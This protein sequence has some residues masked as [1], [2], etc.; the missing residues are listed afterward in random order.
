[1]TVPPTFIRCDPMTTPGPDERLSAYFDGELSA[2]ERA[3]VERLLTERSDLQNELNGLAD[4]SLRLNDLA[5]ELPD[6]D[7]RSRVMAQIDRTRRSTPPMPVRTSPPTRQSWMP[8]FLSVC[9]LALLAAVIWPLL[10]TSGNMPQLA[11]H[12]AAGYKLSQA[13]HSAVNAPISSQGSQLAPNEL[14]IVMTTD[15]SLDEASL[16]PEAVNSTAALSVS[17]DGKGPSVI[18]AQIERSRGLKAGEIVS[19]MIQSGD[20]P[21]LAEYTVVDVRRSAQDVEVL[22][23]EHGIQPL[24]TLA[25]DSRNA[26]Q[27]ATVT[28]DTESPLRVYLLD[29]ETVS[30]NTAITE[31]KGLQEV[32]ATKVESYN[33]SPQVESIF[34]GERA[35]GAPSFFAQDSIAPTAPTGRF[36]E[37]LDG[38]QPAFPAK[39]TG[40]AAR[41]SPVRGKMDA[42]SVT[43][44][45]ESPPADAKAPAVTV[46]QSRWPLSTSSVNS[47]PANIAGNSLVVE[48]GVEV[49]A[50]LQNAMNQT[51]LALQANQRPQVFPADVNQNSIVESRVKDDINSVTRPESQRMSM[52]WR[53][54]SMP[55]QQKQINLSRQR[56]FLVLRP[57]VPPASPSQPPMSSPQS[58]ASAQ[59]PEP[60]QPV[61]VQAPD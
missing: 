34:T 27:P 1:M 60:P 57:Q 28:A 45:S 36:H 54:Q 18:L 19:R 2:A 12:D 51:K 6:F 55:K 42:Y 44:P 43:E 21:M 5:E 25:S 59:P 10:L 31:C 58:A 35:P 38:S 49:Y 9:S 32:V 40:P 22:L 52:N 47:L 56:A 24:T 53:N 17:P 7:L 46:E 50:E 15:R 3:E 11:Q 41:R 48:N 8:L 23:K 39:S 13:T 14:G 26:G 16:S 37:S 30:L 33:I 4:L 29:A 20:T 61:P